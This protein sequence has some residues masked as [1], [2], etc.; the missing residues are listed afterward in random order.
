L[1]NNVGTGDL[2]ADKSSEKCVFRLYN[3]HNAVS[4]NA[5][6]Y[7]LFSKMMKPEAMA[8]TSDAL[9]F[10]LIRVHYQAMI[11]RNAHGPT[12]Q[13]PTP[14]EMDGDLTNQGYSPYLRQRV[15]FLTVALSKHWYVLHVG[16]NARTE[17]AARTRLNMWSSPVLPTLF[18]ALSSR[19]VELK[20][21][22]LYANM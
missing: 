12:P 5:V 4:V 9:H 21:T 18:T 22:R 14:S 1:L 13:L 19:R 20:H 11:W 16:L 6:R 7:L 10:H 8:S 17:C 3:V 2:T 15:L